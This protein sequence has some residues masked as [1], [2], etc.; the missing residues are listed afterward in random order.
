M[1]V[2]FPLDMSL[3]VGVLEH[4][5]LLFFFNLGDTSI[6]FH[7]MAALSNIHASSLALA[8]FGRFDG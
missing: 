1:M 8:S 6:V 5:L 3:P 7:I 4:I 2:L